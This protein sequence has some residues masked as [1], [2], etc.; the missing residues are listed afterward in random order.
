MEKITVEQLKEIGFVEPSEDKHELYK[1]WFPLEYKLV[2]VEDNEG[3]N[4]YLALTREN[5]SLELTLRL[6]DGT[7]IYFNPRNIDDIK[8]LQETI[9]SIDFNY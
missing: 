3:E 6:S 2:N 1:A 4:P 7:N 9:S 8:V 5:N